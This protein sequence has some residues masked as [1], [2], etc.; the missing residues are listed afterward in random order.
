MIK[1]VMTSQNVIS[2]LSATPK[3]E[4][5]LFAPIQAVLCLVCQRNALLV[6][7]I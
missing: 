2:V 7:P 6:Y 5:S 4:I 1:F 3:I